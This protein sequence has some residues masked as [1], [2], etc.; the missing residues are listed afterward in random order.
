[1]LFFFAT[2]SLFVTCAPEQTADTSQKRLINDVLVPIYI[3]HHHYQ[4][5]VQLLNQDKVSEI[6]E[7]YK[8][9]SGEVSDKYLYTFSNGKLSTVYR[10]DNKVK[11]KVSEFDY[12]NKGRL[13]TILKFADNSKTYHFEYNDYGL[14]N[15][16]TD[17]NGD[18]LF[19]SKYHFDSSGNVNKMV[20]YYP[21]Q[22]KTNTHNFIKIDLNS[23]SYLL[24][25]YMDTELTYDSM[26]F[27]FN[28]NGTMKEVF[29]EEYDSNGIPIR[30]ISKRGIREIKTE[31]DD[32]GNWILQK[33]GDSYSDKIREIKY[34]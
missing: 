12:D 11:S 24:N 3:S 33:I 15:T 10:I 2:I 17:E 6:V 13:K 29:G 5:N 23:N 14:I 18:S 20:Q 22:G 1:M 28:S 25:F 26:P 16:L 27:A 31:L 21:K 32:K 4:C 30:I 7:Y 8:Y 19:S 34:K 9:S